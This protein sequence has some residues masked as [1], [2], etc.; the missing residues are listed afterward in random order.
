MQSATLYY[1]EGASDKV[2]RV[3][4]EERDGG[5]VVM[6]SPDQHAFWI[7]TSPDTAP[8]RRTGVSHQDGASF[9][10]QAPVEARPCIRTPPIRQ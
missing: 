9:V 8:I 4:L 2:Y 1:R 5:Y 3:S 7:P 6:C 10:A